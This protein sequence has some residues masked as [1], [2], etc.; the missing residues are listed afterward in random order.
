MEL[1][2]A[3]RTLSHREALLKA[4]QSI[5]K[6]KESAG[7]DPSRLKYHFMAPAY[8]INDPNGLIFFKGEYHLFYQHYPYAAEWGP[9]HWGHAKSKDLVHWEHLPIA[10]A[11][12]E[13]YDLDDRGG[14]FSGSAVDD[15]GVLSV[16]YTGT[17]HKDGLLIQSQCL[18]TSLDGITFEKY[19]GN[20]VIPGPPADGSADFRDPK[21]WKHDGTWYMVVGS[22]KDGIGKAL[23]YNSPDLREW[24]YAG[25]LAESDGTMGTMWECPDFF[26]LDGR[27]VLMFSPMGM[28]QR[29]TI[30]LVGDMNYTTGR[31]TWDTMGDVDYGYE[32]YAP[33]SFSGGQ[34]RRIIIAWL[35]AW[36]WMPWFKNFGPTS[37]NHWCGAMSAPRTVEL[38]EDGRLEFKPVK[39]LEVLRRE[40]YHI[41]QTELSPEVQLIPKYLGSDCLEIK[42]E[43]EMSG[44]TAEEI[45]F[46]LRSSGDGVQQTLLVYDKR[47]G[48]LT[49]DRSRSDGWSEGTPTAALERTGAEPLRL[50]IFVDTSVVEVYTDNYRTVMTNNI[51]P[52]PASIGLE[53]FVRGGSVNITSLDVWKLRSA[54]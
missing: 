52:N 47:T 46:L 38:A 54:W 1:L 26:P 5:S 14:V 6:I 37:K 17:I 53:V 16:L 19:E 25:V 33:Q 13:P 35:N 28:G 30:Y 45:G 40:H 22:S 44:C 2:P 32:Y 29:K 11:P 20:P 34:G 12:S 31:F 21:V 9:M 18:A 23:L 50:H 43:F 8:W 51:Y 36:D 41:E 24:N 3:K 15:N 4:E 27:Y 49:F 7:K 10:L 48:T 39:E 42:A